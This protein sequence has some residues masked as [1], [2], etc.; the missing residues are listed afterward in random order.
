MAEQYRDD[1]EAKE[2]QRKATGAETPKAPPKVTPGDV[3]KAREEQIKQTEEVR[4]AV[5][6]RER[7]ALEEKQKFEDARFKEESEAKIKQG[8]EVARIAGMSLEDKMAEATP[9][10]A[11]T[12]HYPVLSQPHPPTEFVLSEANGHRSRANA[13]LADPAT[14]YVGMPLKKTADPT[15]TQF[16]TYV[17]AAAGADCQ[18]LAL[19]AGNTIPGE[20][21][22]ISIIVR[23]AE[24]NRHCLTWP[25]GMTEA[26]KTIG[27]TTLA[28]AGIIVRV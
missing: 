3:A 5:H 18:A 12:P 11:T 9:F 2:A 15:A 8:Q 1:N 21:M 26:E 7:L 13:Y 23:D 24:V 28:A 27:V 17:P 16:A 10:I 19:Y 14:V 22:A 4:K 6:E 25:A 20:G